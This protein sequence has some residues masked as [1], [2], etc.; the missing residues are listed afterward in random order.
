[1]GATVL[2]ALVRENFLSCTEAGV[3]VR[4]TIMREPAATTRLQE[5]FRSCATSLGKAYT[6]FALLS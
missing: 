1:M 2:R 6:E 3:F 4:S 5:N